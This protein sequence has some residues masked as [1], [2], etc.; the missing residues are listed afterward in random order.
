MKKS[1][2]NKIFNSKIFIILFSL[3]LSFTLW[4]YISS[5]NGDT[6]TRTFKQVPVMFTG[7]DTLKSSRDMV[8]TDP[9]I[10]YVT[11]EINGPRKIITGL[12]STD[13]AAVV[14]V[15]K[16]SVAMYTSQQYT[17]SFPDGTD[18][19]SITVT[20]KT[21]ESVN[22]MVSRLTSKTVPVKGSFTGTIAEGFT[23]MK[24]TYDPSTITVSGPE[25]YL[26]DI[27]YVAVSFGSSEIS[28]SYSENAVFTPMSDEGEE[29]SR[30]GLTFSD[31]MI[32][33]TIPVLAVKDVPL[34]I[35]LIYSAG[36]ADY[37]TIVT[38]E[39][40][41]ITLSGDSSIL[42]EINRIVVATVNTGDFL[43]T[44]TD[45]YQIKIDN[46]LNNLT[47]VTEASVTVSFSGLAS[48]SFNV[49]NISVTGVP[50][51][52]EYE[53]IT[54]KLNV[55]VRASEE[56]LSSINSENI[57]AT[58]NLSDTAVSEGL[59]TAPAKISIDGAINAGSVGDDCNI[60][61]ILR[62]IAA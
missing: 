56:E 59:I 45:T 10:S 34:D 60:S 2:N 52:Y 20:E 51:G 55:L 13:L 27:D 43:S 6:Y 19:S 40:A 41:Y 25:A 33:C 5:L 50:E 61:I 15:S 31:E 30:T 39:P 9:D 32:L 26:K 23:S 16:L 11:V 28:S 44:F 57:R 4:L 29:I 53:L 24:V 3:A 8:V 42:D 46:E 18:L 47:G 38:I 58:L 14:D 37:N 48:K 36:A 54:T 7:E 12:S 49:T 62:R 17:I 21:P 1:Q 22:F 35:N